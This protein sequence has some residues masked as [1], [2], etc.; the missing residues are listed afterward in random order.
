MSS[1]AQK[2]TFS[3]NNKTFIDIFN[4]VNSSYILNERRN[5]HS[6]SLVKKH[7]KELEFKI[8]RWVIFFFFN[9]INYYFLYYNY[10]SYL[11]NNIN[12]L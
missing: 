12:I 5:F 2:F 1:I 3:I 4:K 7:Y 10:F 8:Y 9:S 11:F 6:S